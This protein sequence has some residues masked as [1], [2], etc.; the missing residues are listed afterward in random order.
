MNAQ[1][2]ALPDATALAG[3]TPPVAFAFL[4]VVALAMLLFYFGGA[5]R[6]RIRTPPPTGPPVEP[7][8][9]SPPALPAA[10]D[11]ADLLS[12]QYIASLKDQVATQQRRIDALEREI[13][14]LRA[15]L[16]RLRWRGPP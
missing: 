14:R 1:A 3:L 8:Q 11:R 6:E 9:P 10:L 4:G 16:D 5:V 15:E 12:D 7:A 13:D 2:P